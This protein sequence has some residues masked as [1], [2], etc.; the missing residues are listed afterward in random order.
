MHQSNLY[1]SQHGR[2]LNLSVEE[3]L[4][5]LGIMIYSGYRP[6]HGKYQLWSNED[7]VS[8]K[9]AKDLMPKNRM[10]EILRNLHLANNY[11]IDTSD[12]YYKV[13]PLFEHLNRS[14][15]QSMPMNENLSVDEIMVPYFG[16]HGTKQYIRGKPIRYG[17]KLWALA[18]STGYLYSVEPYCRSSTL[19]PA[20][21]NGMGYD[22]VMGLAEKAELNEG[23]YLYF[24]NLFTS[25]GLLDRLT[26]KKL[27]V[28]AQFE[29]IEWKVHH[30]RV[31]K[32]LKRRR[33]VPPSG[34]QMVKTF[35]SGGMTIKQ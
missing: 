27:E 4:G 25:L 12:P 21:G 6:V 32:S 18:S 11:E 10:I 7:D 22:V 23:H 31:G 3:F 13:R 15:V 1:A 29:K 20:S 9:W 16:R 8:F 28:A 19:L 33:E 5:L 2:N 30:C 34:L 35:F 17:Y 26:E 24:D 14:F